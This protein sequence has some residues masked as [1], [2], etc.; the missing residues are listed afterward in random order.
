MFV[1]S[2]KYNEAL[3]YI[4]LVLNSPYI[5]IRRDIEYNA[6]LLNLI[7]HYELKNFEYLEYLIVSTYRFLYKRKK[8]FKLEMYVTNFIRRLTKIKSDKDLKNSFIILRNELLTIYHET[9]E[10]NIFLYF[11]YLKWVNKKI[12]E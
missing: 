3:K 5:S 8:I 6:R 1:E 10:K 2:G 4:N 9:H 12:K 7:I 11:D